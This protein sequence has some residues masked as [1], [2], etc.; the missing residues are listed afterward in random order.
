MNIKTIL[1]VQMNYVVCG[2]KINSDS[3]NFVIQTSILNVNLRDTK[4]LDHS[5]HVYNVQRQ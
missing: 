5:K 2:L 1:N 3:A 4:L